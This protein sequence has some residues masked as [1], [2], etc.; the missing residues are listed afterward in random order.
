MIASA[1][2]CGDKSPTMP[3][4][5]P[6]PP[7]PDA[8]ESPP[9]DA[10]PAPAMSLLRVL[11]ASPVAANLDVYVA[12]STTPLFSNVA[13]GSVTAYATIPARLDP[14][15]RAGW[16]APRRGEDRATTW[17]PTTLAPLPPPPTPASPLRTARRR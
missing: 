4:D 10:P 5:A 11:H 7:S 2:A 8:P 16:T 15:R 12:G 13:Y 3:P 6:Q 9:P 14:C 17:T 1:A